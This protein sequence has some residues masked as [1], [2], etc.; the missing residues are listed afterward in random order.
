[1]EK[2]KVVITNKI[3]GDSERVMTLNQ[4]KEFNVVAY[5]LAKKSLA[6]GGKSF[7][8]GMWTVSKEMGS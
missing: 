1:M 4:L 8:S 7:T 6:C 2:F 3:L 5:T